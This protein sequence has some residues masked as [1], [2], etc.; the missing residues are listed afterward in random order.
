MNEAGPI[1]DI[2]ACE[3]AIQTAAQYKSAHSLKGYKS[4]LI[5]T[6]LM[7]RGPTGTRN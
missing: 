1:T 6:W 3:D 2:A 7:E 5:F 4:S